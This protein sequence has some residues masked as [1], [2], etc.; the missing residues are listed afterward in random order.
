MIEQLGAC[1]GHA[2]CS[3]RLVEEKRHQEAGNGGSKA[4]EREETEEAFKSIQASRDNNVSAGMKITTST[5]TYA[6]LSSYLL[7]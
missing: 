3:S 7:D 1:V 6:C 2:I 5:P 4:S